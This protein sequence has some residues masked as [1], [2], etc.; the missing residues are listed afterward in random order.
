MGVDVRASLVE[1]GGSPGPIAVC[2]EAAISCELDGV[3]VA[4]RPAVG[5]CP[6]RTLI[7]VGVAGRAFGVGEGM[8][9][10]LV[11]TGGR[12]STAASAAATGTTTHNVG[13]HHPRMNPMIRVKFASEI[14]VVHGFRASE[15]EVTEWCSFTLA[16]D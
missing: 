7:T 4:V 8:P 10:A 13:N 2:D 16:S 1:E 6:V 11:M 5:G 9:S 14:G 3:P 12:E 15:A